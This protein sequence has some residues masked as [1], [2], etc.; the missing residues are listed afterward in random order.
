MIRPLSKENYA[1]AARL[2]AETTEWQFFTIPPVDPS[3]F[4]HVLTAPSSCFYELIN[5]EDKFV[6]L[7]G[8]ENIKWID[9]TAEPVIVI[10]PELR[11]SPRVATKF[12]VSLFETLPKKLGIRRVHSIVLRDSP[13]IPLLKHLGFRHEGTLERVRY[14]DGLFLDADVYA[15]M[16]EEV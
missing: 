7:G 4:I 2:Y 10:A 5:K 6:G 1:D 16:F 12:A 14:K 8:L 3:A 13:S 15:L 11:G 9:K